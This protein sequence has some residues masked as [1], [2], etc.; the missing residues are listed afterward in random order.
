MPDIEF[1]INGKSFTL[2][3]TDYVLQ[4]HYIRIIQEIHLYIE[5]IDWMHIGL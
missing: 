1:I 3:P 4:V 2:T 5:V